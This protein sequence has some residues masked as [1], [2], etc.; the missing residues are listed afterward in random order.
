MVKYRTNFHANGAWVYRHAQMTHVNGAWV[1][2]PVPHWHVS[3]GAQVNRARYT[4]T[5]LPSPPPR[6]QWRPSVSL[7]ASAGGRYDLRA[8]CA[9]KGDFV[10]LCF[11]VRPEYGVNLVV[12]QVC[13]CVC[14][15]CVCACGSCVCVCVVRVCVC[16]V[17]V[18]VCVSVFVSVF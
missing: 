6:A 13:V 15:S 14:G 4:G 8:A 1:N 16:V 12:A 5:S 18:C 10:P 17:R 3:F 11:C 7:S 2:R 9:D